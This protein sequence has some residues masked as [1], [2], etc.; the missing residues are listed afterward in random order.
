MRRLLL[1][2]CN[3]FTLTLLG[4]TI[5]FDIYLWGNKIGQMI[6]SRE[7]EGEGVIHYHLRSHTQAKVLWIKREG[8]SEYDAWYSNGKLV[9]SSLRELENGKQKRF[10]AVTKI[11]T[12]YRIDN[13]RKKTTMTQLPDDDIMGFY[14]TSKPTTA[15]VFYQPEAEILP[16]KQQDAH[17]WWFKSSDGQTNIYRYQ[18]GKIAELEFQL[19]LA[20]V[21]MKR[22]PE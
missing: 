19:P 4:E 2:L 13:Y 5:S 6:V 1:I 14:F 7:T 11:A 3:L 10:S 9:R 12:G 18:N 8:I 17:T 21:V 15:E 16:V 20:S 22:I